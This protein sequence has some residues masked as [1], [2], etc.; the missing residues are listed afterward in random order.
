[1][2]GINDVAFFSARAHAL[3]NVQQVKIDPA[4]SALQR[5]VA[6]Q[7]KL[8]PDDALLAAQLRINLA[9]VTLRQGKSEE[10][11]RQ[12]RDILADPMFTTRRI[13]EHYVS[14]LQL[15]LARALRN[16]G[17]YDEALPL[18][19]AAV[20]ATE[21]VLGPDQYQT[22]VQWSTVA[23]IYDLMG[24]CAK[25]LDIQRHVWRAMAEHV[26]ATKQSTLAEAGNLAD[27]EFECGDKDEGIARMSEAVRDLR[28]YYGGDANPH[29]Q[30]FRFE[31]A[32]MLTER[33]R[34]DEALVQLQG[35][36]P[37]IMTESDSTAG[38][39]VRLK[40]LRGRIL[41]LDGQVDQ[42]RKLLAEA[43]PALITLGTEDPADI[44]ELNRLMGDGQGDKLMQ[45]SPTTRTASA[46][47]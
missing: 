30:M 26:G 10:A 24:Q 22:L 29:S 4:A 5:A 28:Q 6:L 37:A 44:R 27:M 16:V 15:N 47:H 31:L 2:T 43:I 46:M 12:M 17:R 32:G 21:R 14:A 25:G 18:A 3:L 40:A 42:G 23:G 36:S 34:Y 9:D 19:R 1:M 35:L 7:R 13:G 8:H 39:D 38:W 11:I 33:H 20:E 41:V 45:S